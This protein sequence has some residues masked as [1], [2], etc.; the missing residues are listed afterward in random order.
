MT[1]SNLIALSVA[2]SS[3]RPVP[4]EFRIFPIGKFKSE[5]GTFVLTRAAAQKIV[6]DWAT[7]NTQPFIDYE[8]QVTSGGVAP[9]A[10]WFHLALRADGLYATGIKWTARATEYLKA[11]EYRFFSPLFG[12]DNADKTA[13]VSLANVALTNFPAMHSITPLVAAKAAP[14]AARTQAPLA[15]KGK[16]KMSLDPKLVSEIM[17]LIEE[18][19]GAAGKAVDPEAAA[20]SVSASSD[21]AAPEEKPV[22]AEAEVPVAP[23]STEDMGEPDKF[24]MDVRAAL[25]LD[26]SASDEEVLGAI[27]ALVDG[28]GEAEALKVQLSAAQEVGRV[29]LR[30]SLIT[31]GLRVKAISLSD[32]DT[33]R[34]TDKGDGYVKAYIEQKKRSVPTRVM[35]P[36]LVATKSDMAVDAI[37]MQL[38]G[39]SVR[40]L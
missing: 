39:E 10:G 22:A 17:A 27:Q 8:H 38:R 3:A 16:T 15:A 37:L 11:G 6:R 14:V 26:D 36:A 12:V 20:P 24:D 9:A 31:E 21:M 19:L 30:E 29:A 34:G 1:M 18:K 13:V 7:K 32:A 25:S 23:V 33:L 28:S 4:S 5:K 35:Q 2:A 40:P